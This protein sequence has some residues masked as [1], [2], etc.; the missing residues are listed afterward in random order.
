[1]G[2]LGY[3]A[4]I[5]LDG[6][7]ADANGDFDWTAPGGDLFRFHVERMTSVSHE[8]L[9]RNTYQLMTYWQSEPEDGSW[10][11]DEHEFARL[12]QDLTRTAVSSTMTEAD[13]VSDRDRLLPRLDIAGLQQIVDD[14]EGEV[15]IFGPTTASEAISAGM[16]DQFRFFIVPRVVGGGLRALPPGAE[17]DLELVEHRV[18]DNG[19]ALLHY[20]RRDAERSS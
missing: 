9:G 3:T 2:T 4:T 13:L 16:V 11:P 15:E 19:A 7:A 1:M 14:A 12:W 6:Y 18:F 10:S 17:L 5:S 20:R 8:V